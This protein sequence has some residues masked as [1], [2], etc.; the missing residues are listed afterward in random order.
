MLRNQLF[1]TAGLATIIAVAPTAIVQPAAAQDARATAIYEEGIA[2]NGALAT[3]R[4][5]VQ[6]TLNGLPAS[7]ACP[8]GT[9]DRATDLTAAN[10]LRARATTLGRRVSQLQR[11]YTAA[12]DDRS[13]LG[14]TSARALESLD[15]GTANLNAMRGAQQDIVGSIGALTRT[16]NERPKTQA[17]CDGTDDPVASI[18]FAPASVE[19]GTRVNAGISARTASGTAVNISSVTVTGM[20]AFATLENTR[21]PGGAANITF[22]IDDVRRPGPF[23]VSITVQGAPAGA[24]AGA[25]GTRYTQ[26][27]SYTVANAAPR[28]VSMPAAP[29]GEPG[30]DVSISGDIVIID[31]NADNRNANEIGRQGI[32]LG[33]H[34]A[35]LLTTPDGA[36]GRNLAI[37]NRRHDP[38]TGQYT[39]KI[40][41]SATAKYPHAHGQFEASVSVTDKDGKSTSEAF[42]VTILNTPPEPRFTSPRAPGNAY[43]SGDGEMVAIKGTVKDANGRD[44]ITSI[45]IDATDAGG[46]TY[47]MFDGV[48][49]LDVTPTG[50]DGVRFEIV[51]EGPRFECQ[52]SARGA[53]RYARPT[54]LRT[55]S[56]GRHA[57]SAPW[58]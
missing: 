3:L 6:Q 50:D 22:K 57:R 27:F 29:S 35:G 55:Q 23:P 32:K 54:A 41:R 20:D 39:F 13:V 53:T 7:Y 28:I 4:I 9:P 1:H 5:D 15:F 10:A 31:T 30:D 43:H 21:T 11:D 14:E 2:I 56:C 12:I 51:P 36:F 45:E 19:P 17:E 46:G 42:N 58:Q 37:T 33:G 47:R 49:T 24:P 38:S 44:D 34:P 25:T 40:E 52:G 8:P 26:R 18:S 48:K 16:I